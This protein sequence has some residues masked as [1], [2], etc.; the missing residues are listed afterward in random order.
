MRDL[1]VRD[2][3]TT[4][5][6]RAEL[7]CQYYAAIGLGTLEVLFLGDD[8][9]EIASPSSHLEQGWIKKWGTY[10]KPVNYIGVGYIS[11][12]LAAVLGQPVR[13]FNTFEV[14]SIVV[15]DA[16]TIFKSYKK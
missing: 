5:A 8:S 13:S 15:G 10:D 3:A 7:A 14:A 16:K 1:F 6:H 11:A 4:L 9:G 2:N 12:M